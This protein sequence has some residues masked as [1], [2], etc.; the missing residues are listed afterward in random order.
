VRLFK[1]MGVVMGNLRFQTNRHKVRF[2]V[3]NFRRDENALYV[4]ERIERTLGNSLHLSF[5][6]AASRP[7]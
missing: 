6:R 1:A 2:T 7:H 4:S 3:E 5:Y